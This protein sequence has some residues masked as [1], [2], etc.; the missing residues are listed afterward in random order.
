MKNKLLVLGLALFTSMLAQAQEPTNWCG[1]VSTIDPDYSSKKYELFERARMKGWSKT[2]ESDLLKIPLTGHLIRRTDGTGGLSEADFLAEL[3]GVNAAYYEGGIQF[4]LCGAINE[5]WDDTYFNYSSSE[6]DALM[7]AHGVENT[8]NIFVA[9]EARSGNTPVCGYSYYPWSQ[10]DLVILARSCATNG[11]TFAH[12]LGHNLGL[13]HT[14]DSSNGA[15]LVDGSNCEDA[16]DLLC[17][18]PADPNLSGQVNTSC[19]Y[20]GGD[21]D[22]NGDP[23]A[24]DVSNM[25]SYARKSCRTH[26]SIGQ[27]VRSAYH[28][29]LYKEHL[30]CNQ[31][32]NGDVSLNSPALSATSITTGEDFTASITQ[33]YSGDSVE[34]IYPLMSYY[35][36]SDSVFDGSDLYLGSN[37]SSLKGGNDFEEESETLSL[38]NETP[39]GD[40]YLLFVAESAQRIAET[41]ESNNVLFISITVNGATAYNIDVID[42]PTGAGVLTGAGLYI[43]NQTV[44][45]TASPASADWKF[46]RWTKDG[47]EVSTD[48]AY[49]FNATEVATYVAEFQS[50]IGLSEYGIG[51][52]TL[53][54]NPVQDVLTLSAPNNK[55]AYTLQI[56]N[57]L[58]D[59]LITEKVN[60]GI[61]E[62]QI[63]VSQLEKG[64]YWILI[65][66]DNEVTGLS[67]VKY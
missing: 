26:M 14:H 40:H 65:Q 42:N 9:D 15:E 51:T 22:A 28:I 21:T 60:T 13:Y 25:M 41:D 47:Q 17:D 10:R 36:S 11:S 23:Y 31:N 63:Q 3:E 48:T 29:P 66:S 4:Y 24:P 2:D 32:L 59:V 53:F 8:I 35:L 1:T 33:T 39:T 37:I 7:M 18:T 34:A 46:N 12:E 64:L 54:P 62:H 6:E 61:S 55:D 52:L 16:G 58:G 67:F 57:S 49:T 19:M 38:P 44:T 30:T 20:T 43:E 5:I 27:Q 50:T 45:I 56:V